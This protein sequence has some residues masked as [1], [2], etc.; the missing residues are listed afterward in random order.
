MAEAANKRIFIT[1]VAGFI[2]SNLAAAL[3]NRGYKVIG[4]D[5]L[6]QGLR[7]N[8]APIMK[9]R[10]FTF[11]KGDVRNGGFVEKLAKGADVI[12]HLAAYKIPRYGNAMDTLMINSTGT[13]NA[14]EAA[15]KNKSKFVFTSTSDVYGKLPDIPFREDGDILLG[16][17]KVKRWAYAASKLFDEHLCF[18]YEEKYGLKVAILRIFGSYGSNQNLTWWGGPQSGFITAAFLK[19][20]MQIHGDGSQTRSFTYIDDTVDGIVRAIERKESAGELI[21]I[22]NDKEIS[23]LNLARLIWKMVN[24]NSKPR[25]KFVPYKTFSGKNYQDVMRRVPDISKAARLLGFRPRVCL[26][27][28]LLKTIAWQR[29][30]ADNA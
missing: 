29:R 9:N 15:K 19:E 24:G 5:N 17:S 1:G 11:V 10:N 3:L 12:V 13:M 20:P 22:G 4:L 26:K 25:L 6:S 21:N 16:H 27:E 2:G 23:I 14:L 18:A 28:G 8:I 7:R 30:C